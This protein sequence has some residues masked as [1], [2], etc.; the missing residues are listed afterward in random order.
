MANLFKIKIL[1]KERNIFIRALANAVG[2][3]EQGLQLLIR[4]NS[5]KIDTLEKIAS[6]L[7]VPISV[8]FDENNTIN[9]KSDSKNA[10]DIYSNASNSSSIT[11]Y[12]EKISHLEQLLTE[13]EKQIILLNKICEIQYK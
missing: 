3:T 8:F 9:Q 2:I 11:S 6:V 5:T 4:E 10:V 7:N 12:I 13:K 1:A